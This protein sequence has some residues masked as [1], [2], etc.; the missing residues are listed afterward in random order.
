MFQPTEDRA[1][2]NTDIFTLVRRSACW[3]GENGHEVSWSNL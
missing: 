3:V 2:A 1:T